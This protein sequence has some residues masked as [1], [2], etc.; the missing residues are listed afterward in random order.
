MFRNGQIDEIQRKE[1]KWERVKVGEY[2]ATYRGQ[3]CILVMNDFPDEP[4][5][6]LTYNN[7]SVDFDDKPP[8]W[9]IP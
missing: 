8:C 6:T 7:E 4:L 2:V 1:I 9:F 5:Y 3:K